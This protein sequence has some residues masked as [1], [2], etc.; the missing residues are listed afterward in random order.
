LGA[1]PSN[2]PSGSRGPT[3]PRGTVLLCQQS[4]N[5]NGNEDGKPQSTVIVEAVEP[6]NGSSLAS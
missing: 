6:F 4:A 5:W 2:A 1:V 3:L